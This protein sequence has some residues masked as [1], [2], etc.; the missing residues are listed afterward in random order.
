M[1]ES[2]QNEKD[3][4]ILRSTDL[5]HDLVWKCND[6]QELK[7]HTPLTSANNSVSSVLTQI[8]VFTRDQCSS[9]FTCE[10]TLKDHK[11]ATHRLL[12]PDGDANPAVP[13]DTTEHAPKDN[14]DDA[15]TLQTEVLP[16]PHQPSLNL[17]VRRMSMPPP[18]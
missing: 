8:G 12:L 2:L 9:T 4:H 3:S 1:T 7:S 17:S 6:P 14:D 5:K 13:L 10:S 16:P 11:T 15:D 18:L